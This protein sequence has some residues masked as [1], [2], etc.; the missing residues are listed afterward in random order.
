[1]AKKLIFLLFVLV[2]V[3]YSQEMELKTGQVGLDFSIFSYKTE[4]KLEQKR[5]S[6]LKAGLMS[7]LIPGS[8]EFYTKSYIKS[9]LFFTAEVVLWVVYFNYTRKGD[10]QTRWFKRYADENWS[11]VDYA[12]WINEWMRRYGG[13]DAPRLS[14]DPNE[15]L[16]PWQRVNWSRLNGGRKDI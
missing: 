1:M 15:N 4:D 9:A 16:K 14:I 6:P 3:V 12:S 11:V 7:A 13:H 10:E 5:Y 2:C 8:G